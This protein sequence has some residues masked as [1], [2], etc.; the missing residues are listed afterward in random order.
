M[1][2]SRK[3]ATFYRAGGVYRLSNYWLY[4]QFSPESARNVFWEYFQKI[5]EFTVSGTVAHINIIN[6][7]FDY[8]VFPSRKVIKHGFIF[9]TFPGLGYSA[10]E[11]ELLYK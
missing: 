4:S 7:P 8:S 6:H 1:Y 2:E 10:S 5:P 9:G 3:A 11:F